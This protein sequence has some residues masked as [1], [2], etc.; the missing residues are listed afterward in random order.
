VITASGDPLAPGLAK[1]CSSLVTSQYWSR[2]TTEYGLGAPRSC[3]HVVG[4]A[5]AAG[6]VN[7]AQM[8]QYIA[9]SIGAAQPDGATMYLL[10]LPPG[11]QFAG[12]NNCSFSGYHGKYG[13]LGDAWGVVMRCQYDFASMLESLTIVGSHEIVEAATDPDVA[14]GWG[15]Y[16]TAAQPWTQSAWL[17]YGGGYAVENADYCI[18]T[19]V[20][21]DGVA[22]Q[23]VLSNVAAAAGDD[24]CVPAL[25]VPYY[26]VTVPEDWYAVAPGSTVDIPITGWSNAPA[27]MWQISAAAAESSTPPPAVMS[28]S[29]EGQDVTIGDVTYHAMTAGQ[30]SIMHV[31]MNTTAQSGTWRVFWL[32]SFRVDSTGA[33][34]IAGDDHDHLWRV[35]VYVP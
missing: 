15:Q 11:V 16:P 2:V 1:F 18:S 9:S 5:M 7:Y 4:A 22:Y 3:S 21:E 26:N 8:H 31:T 29:I 23:R 35:G 32:Y 34:G 25:A 24:P 6:T 19:R 12:A 17:P 30:T 20:I 14:T 27:E 13:M 33:D 10:I 28:R